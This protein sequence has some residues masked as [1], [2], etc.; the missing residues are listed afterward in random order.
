MFGDPSFLAYYLLGP[1]AVFAHVACGARSLSLRRLGPVRAERLA[2]SVLGVGAAVTLVI[3]LA[4][5]G[6][7]LRNDRD[8]PQPRPAKV[9]W[10]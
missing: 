2:S 7:H 5:C 8:R 9:G 6:I 4:L 3:G 1:L 10:R